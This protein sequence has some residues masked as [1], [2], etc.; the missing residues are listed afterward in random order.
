MVLDFRG[1]KAGQREGP[2]ASGSQR[3]LASMMG[4]GVLGSV[5]GK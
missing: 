3:G 2:S 4:E 1:G 5:F